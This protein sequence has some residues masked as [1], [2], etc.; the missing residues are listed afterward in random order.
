[1]NPAEIEKA[2]KLAREQM[3]ADVIR[4]G[5]HAEFRRFMRRF[6][7]EM[8]KTPFCGEGT[9]ATAFAAGRA[10][11][12]HEVMDDVLHADLNLYLALVREHL[13]TTHA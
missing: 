12:A 9:H 5:A 4:L 10:G 6:V 1:M 13:E 8:Q 7:A 2:R 3:K 11:L